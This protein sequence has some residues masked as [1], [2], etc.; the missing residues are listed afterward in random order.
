MTGDRALAESLLGCGVDRVASLASGGNNRLYRVTVGAADF[1]MKRY[2]ANDPSGRGRFVREIA[3]IRFLSDTYL[4]DRV[5]QLIAADDCKSVALFSWV[6]GARPV[7]RSADD[8][9]QIVDFTRSL[10]ALGDEPA[11]LSLSAAAAACFS[12]ADLIEQID[13][14]RQRLD[15][16]DNE[17]ALA[18]YIGR[19][20]LL[21]SDMRRDV[22]RDCSYEPL[23]MNL[24]VLSPSDF[25]FHNTLRQAGGQLTFLDFEYFGWDDPVKLT[26]DMLWHPGMALKAD[27]ADMLRTGLQPLFAARDARFAHRLAVML[28]L[29]GLCWCL[30]LL[31]EFLPARW[32][33]RRLAQDADPAAW[34]AAKHRQL[35]KAEHLIA[36]VEACRAEILQ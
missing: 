12:S 22:E 19:F 26:A 23:S 15:R 36:R 20:D 5:P 11:A 3:A 2:G 9:Q 10:L 21:W 16:V 30:I 27:E 32:D 7:E 1:A 18:D 29:Y 28:P 25:G 14:R 8:I 35:A 17:P 31:N 13:G 24:R 6:A 34:A 4:A 33:R